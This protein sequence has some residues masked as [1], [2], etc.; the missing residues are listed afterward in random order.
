MLYLIG[1]DGDVNG[2]LANANNKHFIGDSYKSS[3]SIARQRENQ[4]CLYYTADI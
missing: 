1:T 3:G 2:T 4:S